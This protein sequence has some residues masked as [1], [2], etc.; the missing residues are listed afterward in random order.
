MTA[1]PSDHDLTTDL[2][3][4]RAP[5]SPETGSPP[6]AP[7]ASAR[8]DPGTILASRYRIVSPLGKGGMGEVYRADDLELDTPV[9]LKFLPPSLAADPLR[10]DRLRAE[11]RL[12]RQISHPGVCRVFDIAAATLPGAAVPVYFLTM[13]YVDGEDLASLLRRIGRLPTEKAT[14]LA[15]QLCLALAAAHEVGVVHRDLKP[16]NIMLDSRGK[17]RIMD[18]GIASPATEDPALAAPLAGTPAYMAPEQAAGEPATVRSDIF[19]LGLVLYELFTGKA[20]VTAATLADAREFHRARDLARPSSHIAEFDPA[21]ERAIMRCLERDPANR[22]ASAVAVLAGLPGGDPLAAA[23]AAGETPSPELVAA[24]GGSRLLRPAVAGAW[25]AAAVIVLGAMVALSAHSSR[26]ARVAPAKSREVLADRAR[27]LAA[28]LAPASS[29][30]HSATGMLTRDSFIRAAA[31]APNVEAKWEALEQR[32]P[33]PYAL[34]LRQGP[35]PLEGT[36]GSPLIVDWLSPF[37]INPGETVVRVDGIGRLDYFLSIPARAMPETPAAAPPPEPDWARVFTLAGYDLARMSEAPPERRPTVN[38]DVVRGW[39]CPDPFAPD[40][41]IR[42]TAGAADGRLVYWLIT[43]PF[44]PAPATLGPREAAPQ[45]FWIRIAAPAAA[46]ALL[47]IFSA[48]LL[49]CIRNLRH[50]SGDRATATAAASFL[51]LITT[52][53]LLI[54]ADRFPRFDSIFF[55]GVGFAPA[56][57]LA[58]MFWVFYIA[59][60]P[61]A[62]RTLPHALIGWTRV[63]R[64]RLGD[65]LVGREVLSGVV[66]GSLASGVLAILVLVLLRRAGI[67]PDSPHQRFAT[68]MHLHGPATVASAVID[69]GIGCIMWGTGSLLAF[70]RGTILFKNRIAGAACI[71]LVGVLIQLPA[72]SSGA[73]DWLPALTII[74]AMA[75]VQATRGLLASVVTYFTM[76]VTFMLPVATDW[77]GPYTQSAFIPAA[78]IALLMLWGFLAATGVVRESREGIT[79]G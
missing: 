52:A 74:T 79:N 10:L 31:D 39:S 12:A 55:Q 71:V 7:A 8:L 75:V 69:R 3:R 33:G 34:W 20:G 15:R 14:D 27:E 58:V 24:S 13:E 25:C 70:V 40:Q 56:L 43:Y 44:D 4:E 29:T 41:T 36:A 50:G 45:S 19:S 77:T 32:R 53:S 9:A 63:F 11:V 65:P 73:E 6:G 49:L 64:A 67:D 28:E 16:A 72:L 1:R 48:S 76:T 30:A 21:V 37:P 57:W 5:A 51:L 46:T 68:F 2:A 26:L 62:R 23:I 66:F 42:F 60:E 22:P 35:A 47:F 59:L 78:A 18:F 54:E 38:A 61:S 17:A